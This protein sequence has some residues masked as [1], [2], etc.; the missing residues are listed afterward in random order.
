MKQAETK[1][2]PAPAEIDT[3]YKPE[4]AISAKNKS[5]A[6]TNKIYT[7]TAEALLDTLLVRHPEYR[8]YILEQQVKN[9]SAD[10]KNPLFAKMTI[11]N[12]I[13]KVLHDYLK[14]NF[15]EGSEHAMNPNGGP[16]M[17]IPIDGLIDAIKKI[18]K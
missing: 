15:P 10:K 1:Q 11:E 13:N 6:D 18:F 9:F 8:Q 7:L 17:Q 3:S 16:G 2:Q 5:T 12:K 14:E 4:S